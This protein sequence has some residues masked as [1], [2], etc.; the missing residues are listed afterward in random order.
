MT[1][2]IIFVFVNSIKLDTNSLVISFVFVANRPPRYMGEGFVVLQTADCRITYYQDEPGKLINFAFLDREHSS[3]GFSHE[4]SCMQ[5]GLH[6]ICPPT[7]TSIRQSSLCLLHIILSCSWLSLSLSRQ[8]YTRSK[9][10]IQL[11]W[12][13][14]CAVFCLSSQGS[15]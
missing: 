15:S 11:L 3:L 7:R 14:P 1:G 4:P 2:T 12:Y 10:R 6:V 13:M 8:G 5:C 9:Q